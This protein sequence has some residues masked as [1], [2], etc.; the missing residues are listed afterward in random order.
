M[1]L[2]E[3]LC[4]GTHITLQVADGSRKNVSMFQNGHNFLAEGAR[5]TLSGH[6]GWSPS[7]GQTCSL[8]G[9]LTCI[10]EA[11]CEVTHP[12]LTP[13]GFPPSPA[14]RFPFWCS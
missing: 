7:D 11:S 14:G 3:M 2:D 13:M 6:D 1:G 8:A 5:S 4:D 12:S 9:V 10:V